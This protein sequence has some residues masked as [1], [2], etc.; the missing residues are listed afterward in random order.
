MDHLTDI[1]PIVTKYL[2]EEVLSPEEQAA[3]D[4]WI[5]KGE[6]RSRFLR[7]AAE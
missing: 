5:S 2:R 3:L 6:G 4:L 1:D 7:C